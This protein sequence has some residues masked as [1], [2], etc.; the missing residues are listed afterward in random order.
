MKAAG[1]RLFELHSKDL[2]VWNGAESQ[3]DVGEEI[4]PIVTIFRL[5]REVGFTGFANLEYET[6]LGASPSPADDARSCSLRRNRATW[7]LRWEPLLAE[8]RRAPFGA[9]VRPGR[10]PTPSSRAT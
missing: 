10:Q 7:D 1:P 2:K 8:A 5:L 3:C 6:G 9:G 4:L